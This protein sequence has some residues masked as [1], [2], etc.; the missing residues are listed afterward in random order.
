MNSELESD[1]SYSAAFTGAEYAVESEDEDDGRL[2][3]S[4]VVEV[5][6]CRPSLLSLDMPTTAL[7]TDRPANVIRGEED[8]SNPAS[9]DEDQHFMETKPSTVATLYP[10][11]V[12][13]DNHPMPHQENEIRIKVEASPDI[14]GASVTVEP[15]HLQ[16]FPAVAPPSRPPNI[17]TII[18]PFLLQYR[19]P[20]RP[21][22][23][24]HNGYPPPVQE[25]R[26]PQPSKWN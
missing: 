16:S 21:P 19:I 9:D 25:A 2:G 26:N 1:T 6:P 12:F 11:P 3:A 20:L 4:L 23:T 8:S 18:R 13:Y 22:L 10:A 14:H 15:S 5:E 24:M 17:N 7:V